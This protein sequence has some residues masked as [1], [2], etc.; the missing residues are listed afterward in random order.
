MAGFAFT[1]EVPAA[2]PPRSQRSPAPLDG[3]SISEAP[4]ACVHKQPP[5]HTAL[6]NPTFHL[7]APS[8]RIRLHRSLH[9]PFDVP[10]EK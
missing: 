9:V 1:V 6:R 10:E 3:P 2:S 5:S 4:Q 7:P 8:D